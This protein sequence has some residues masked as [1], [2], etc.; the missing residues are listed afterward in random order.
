MSQADVTQPTSGHLGRVAKAASLVMVLFVASRVLG[1]LRE[2]V[3]AR[4]FGTSAEMDA[5]LAAFRLPDFLFYMVAG[6]ALGSAFIPTFTGFLTRR[7]MPGAWRLASAVIN[8][9]LLILSALGGLAAL[10]APWLVQT[11]FGNFDP[12]QQVLTVELM[13]WMLVSTVLFGVIQG[14]VGITDEHF[15]GDVIVGNGARDSEA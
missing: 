14:H 12:A 3:I 9:I 10:F 8:W 7:D 2:V 4:Q 1:L 11:F 6:G 13:R 5:Y 15:R